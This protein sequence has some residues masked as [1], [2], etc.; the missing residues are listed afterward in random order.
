[1]HLRKHPRL[2]DSL[3]HGIHCVIS[4]PERVMNMTERQSGLVPG[5]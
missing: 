4:E 1:M 2:Y 5:Q 3:G